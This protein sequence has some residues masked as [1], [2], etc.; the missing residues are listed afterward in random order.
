MTLNVFEVF[1]SIC[2]DLLIDH[3]SHVK[4]TKGTVDP[5]VIFITARSRRVDFLILKI[6]LDVS[7]CLVHILIKACNTSL[8]LGARK[9]ASLAKLET[10]HKCAWSRA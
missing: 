8:E 1:A 2:S 3:R 9:L 6:E 5:N 10:V 7:R 4:I